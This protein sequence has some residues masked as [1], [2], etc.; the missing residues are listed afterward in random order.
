MILHIVHDQKFI[1]SAFSIFEEVHSQKNEWIVLSETK[2]LNYVKL[3]PCTVVYPDTK[4]LKKLAA[5]TKKYDAVIF[6][7]LDQ[8]KLN[9]LKYLPKNIVT[10]WIGFGTDY[11]D[12]ILKKRTDLFDQKTKRLFVSHYPAAEIKNEIMRD[13][14]YILVRILKKIKRFF[15]RYKTKEELTK[16]ITFFAPV[17]N[18]EYTMIQKALFNRFEP[19]FLDWNYPVFVNGDLDSQYGNSYVKG[20]N[21]L[22]GNNASYENN[23]LETFEILK[24]FDLHDKKIITPLSYGENIY[25]DVIINEG[26]RLFDKNYMPLVNFI[27]IDEYS[28]IISSC[29]IV[30][31]NQIR[32]QALGNIIMMLYLGAM[33]FLKEVNPI[34]RYFKLDGAIIFTIEE[35]EKNPDLIYT[36]LTKEQIEINRD[37][38]KKNWSRK[39]MREKT[40]NVIKILYQSNNE[41]TRRKK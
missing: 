24:K 28:N 40:K 6:H 36:S 9:L 8:Y 7:C 38:L 15:I 29:S 5:I 12:L 31:M 4:N 13:D 34:Y 17:L 30:I 41:K 23:H 26:I 18:E 2:E 21:I 3:T 11:Y 35:L 33:V 39:R 27:P 22:V 16:D 20:S 19:Q 1:D 32:Q 10:L 14:R 25:R 37:I